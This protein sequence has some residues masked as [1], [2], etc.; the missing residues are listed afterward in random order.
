MSNPV[1]WFEIPV[2]NMARAIEFYNTVFDY[3]LK[4]TDLGGLQ[5]AWFPFDH[6]GKG[7]SGSLVLQKEFYVPSENAGV[8]IYFSCSDV[9]VTIEKVIEAGG[10]LVSG[11]KMISPDVGFMGLI[12]D[13]EDNRIALHSRK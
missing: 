12:I 10:K 6:E 11:K 9:S 1:G 5:M 13:T 8:L 4:V 3:D 7:T 2:V